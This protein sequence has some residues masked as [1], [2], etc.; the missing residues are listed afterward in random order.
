LCLN[1]S[2]SSGNNTFLSEYIVLTGD[3]KVTDNEKELEELNLNNAT[4]QSEGSSIEEQ[5]GS[6]A[7]EN[8]NLKDLKEEDSDVQILQDE[9]NSLKE[10]YLRSLADMD[11]LRK[12]CRR[13]IEEARLNGRKNVLEEVLPAL[14]SVDLAL[15]SIEPDGPNQMVYDGM[16]MVQKQFL[17]SMSKFG[18][19]VVEADGA[20]FDPSL[21]EAVSY[22]PSFEVELGVIIE[23]MRKGY[24]IGDRLLRASM[25]VVS[26]GPP[27]EDKNSKNEEVCE[28]FENLNDV[29]S[30]VE[31]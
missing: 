16:L 2:S 1:S 17:S 21:H 26:A 23:E 18:L 20:K 25:V 6:L 14:D 7:P 8:D 29:D 30:E 9:L 12:R 19:K 10:K 15:K 11:N 22:I 5:E 13:D 28:D 31:E 3:N 27:A 24:I 4:E